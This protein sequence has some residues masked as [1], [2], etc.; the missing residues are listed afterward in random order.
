MADPAR[1][2]INQATTREQHSLAEAITAYAEAGVTGISIWRDKLAECGLDEAVH[3]IKDH[4]LRVSGLCRAGQFPAADAKERQ[5]RIDDNLEAVDQAVALGADCLIVVA[6]GL[7]EG[8]KDIS[9]ARQ[10]I[11]DGLGA[12]LPHARAAGMAVAIEPLHPMYAAERCAINTLSQALDLC[13]E[14]GEGIGVAVDVYHVWWDPDLES[15]I[16]RA[17]DRILAYHVCDWLVPTTDLLLDRGMM[18]DGVIDIPLISKWVDGTGYDG[19]IEAEIF[20]AKNW[21]KRSSEEVIR[22]CRERIVTAV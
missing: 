16:N 14:L 8:S 11:R 19:L 12:V 10:M 15:Q 22:T 4:G 2:S 21:W 7:P 3:M 18:G 1:L 6:G 13:D 20:S 5:A 17:A 9:G